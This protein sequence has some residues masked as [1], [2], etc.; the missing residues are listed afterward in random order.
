MNLTL[1]KWGNSIGIRIPKSIRQDANLKEGDTVSMSHKDGII[2][3]SKSKNSVLINCMDC[4]TEMKYTCRINK[5]HQYNCPKCNS[6]VR[7]NNI[8]HVT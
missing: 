8:R 7:S 5:Y 6:E 2:T 4:G 1:R 3:L